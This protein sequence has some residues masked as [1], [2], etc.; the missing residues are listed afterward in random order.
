MQKILKSGF[1]NTIETIQGPKVVRFGNGRGV[2]DS[3]QKAVLATLSARQNPILGRYH[4]PNME[5]ER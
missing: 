2:L 4:I 3:F 1:C 5:A